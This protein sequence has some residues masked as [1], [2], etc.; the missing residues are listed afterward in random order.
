MGKIRV[1]IPSN[2]RR[3]GAKGKPGKILASG[4]GDGSWFSG[5][6][7]VTK[8]G[9]REESPYSII[10]ETVAPSL[11]APIHLHT[12]EDEAWYVL[13]GTLTVR[14]DRRKFQASEGTFFF[15][16]KGIRHGYANRTEAPARALIIISPAGLEGYFE[17][18]GTP[19]ERNELPPRPTAPP[20][21]ERMISMARKYN[22][23]TVEP[24]QFVQ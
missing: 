10:E 17:E 13:G 18:G 9:V 8:V 16:P 20:D 5:N 21:M 24:V 19:A 4:E 22:I 11:G 23:E 3:T 6:L 12:K 7:Y 15:V 1:R 14:L 2:T